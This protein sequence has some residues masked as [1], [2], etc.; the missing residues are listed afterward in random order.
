MQ[1]RPSIQSISSTARRKT[2]PPSLTAI[3]DRGRGAPP[4]GSVPARRMD[5]KSLGPTGPCHGMGMLGLVSRPGKDGGNE[6]GGAGEEGFLGVGGRASG[7]ADPVVGSY[8]FRLWSKSWSG[9]GSGSAGSNWG[10]WSRSSGANPWAT[11]SGSGPSS[12]NSGWGGPRA[13]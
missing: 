6:G 3:F 11:S 7:E 13:G 5:K 12:S 1:Q 9:T 2:R 8:L 10:D 4:P